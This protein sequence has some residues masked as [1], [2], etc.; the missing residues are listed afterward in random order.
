M[1]GPVRLTKQAIADGAKLLAKRDPKLKTIL[2]QFGPPPLL[3]R[4][5]TFAT[6]VHII[7]EQQVSVESAKSTFDRLKAACDQD[8]VPRRVEILGTDRLRELG[9]SRQKAR[10]TLALADDCLERRFVISRLAKLD[11]DAVRAQIVARLGLGNWSAD[12]YMMMALLRPDVFP[13]GDLALVKG[14]QEID[15][16]EYASSE[17]VTTRGEAWRPLRSIATRMVWQ[18]YVHRRGRDI[19]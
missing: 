8:V 6:M 7:L 19:F 13:V 10:Y 15:Q 2:D 9:F 17:E 16:T 4:S 14:M 12:V 3:R 5:A 11:D 18:W 1:S